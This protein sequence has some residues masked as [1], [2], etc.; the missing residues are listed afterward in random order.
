MKNY[1]I[2]HT[3]SSPLHN[4]SHGQVKRTCRTVKNLLRKAKDPYIAILNYRNTP[5]EGIGMSPAQMLILK[6]KLPVANE[7]IAHKKSGEI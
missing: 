1:G 5:I 7:R 2:K 6:T 4:Q 3:T